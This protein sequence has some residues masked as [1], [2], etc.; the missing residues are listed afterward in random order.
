MEIRLDL[1]DVATTGGKLCNLI[2]GSHKDPQSKICQEK[3]LPFNQQQLSFYSTCLKK[4]RGPDKIT[5]R[6]TIFYTSDIDCQWQ[7]QLKSRSKQGW[8]NKQ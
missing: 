4:K 7:A 5:N 1:Q 2:C 8:M 6:E 3:S